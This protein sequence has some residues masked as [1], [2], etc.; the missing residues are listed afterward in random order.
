[1]S[2]ARAWEGRSFTSSGMSGAD[3]GGRARVKP[4]KERVAATGCKAMIRPTPAN[5]SA[6]HSCNA[7]RAS[8]SPTRSEAQRG[9]IAAP[10]RLAPGDRRAVRRVG[11]ISIAS[12]VPKGRMN[13]HTKPNNA[14]RPRNPAAP[15]TVERPS[16]VAASTSPAAV[17]VWNQ[18]AR[19][20]TS[21][22]QLAP[23]TWQASDS[24]VASAMVAA[25]TPACRPRGSRYTQAP[26][27]QAISSIPA[28][29]TPHPRSGGRPVPPGSL[30][31]GG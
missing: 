20:A 3:R 12:G 19:P 29:S 11:S 8:L 9:P 13:S 17:S 15:C 6:A 1:M 22:A 27:M 16:V 23:A 2:C 26:T 4:L 21:V 30:G 31:N 14:C 25:L 7:A 24:G 18:G 28:A 10:T 5:A